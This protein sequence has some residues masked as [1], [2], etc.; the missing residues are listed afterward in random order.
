MSGNFNNGNLGLV[1][2]AQ[3]QYASSTIYIGEV[4]FSRIAAPEYWM[5]INDPDNDAVFTTQ[6][7]RHGNR[8]NYGKNGVLTPISDTKGGSNYAYAD[9]SVQYITILRGAGIYPIFQ[10]AATDPL[11]NQL[12]P[13]NYPSSIYDGD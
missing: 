7:R 11:R 9:G 3:F 10:W 13:R 4:R 5:D 12:S 8:G 6:A 1:K 2:P